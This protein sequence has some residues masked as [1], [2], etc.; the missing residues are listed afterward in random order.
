MVGPT[1]EP[2]NEAEVPAELL[3]Q[4]QSAEE[5]LYPIVMVRPDQ[6]E[7]AVR[8]VGRASG[9]LERLCPDLASLVA[10]A[11]AVPEMVKQI[12][13]EDGLSLVGLDV[14][15]IAGSACSMRYRQ[16][17][18]AAVRQRR[19]DRIAAAAAAGQDWVVLEKGAPPTSW[20]PLPSTTLEMHLPSGRAL[21]QITEVDMETGEP[22][23]A[24]RELTVDPQTGEPEPDQTV[25][26]L[27]YFGNVNDWR[28]AI[29]VRRAGFL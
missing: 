11:L 24:L 10:T 16:L 18:A 19:I 15:L 23:F 17:L 25:S 3:A 1:G 22:R 28:E 4:W 12:A 29:A 5:R 21:Q 7:A 8:L 13:S 2:A 27:E 9:E 26:P 20:P 14:G 6:Y